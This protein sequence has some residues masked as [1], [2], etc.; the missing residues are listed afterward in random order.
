MFEPSDK[1][2]KAEVYTQMYTLHIYFNFFYRFWVICSLTE[3]KSKQNNNS[4]KTL[5]QPCTSSQKS[6]EASFGAVGVTV[7]THRGDRWWCHN[8]WLL[9]MKAA[10]SEHEKSTRANGSNGKQ[11]QCYYSGRRVDIFRPSF[12]SD[13]KT[14]LN[15]LLKDA[16]MILFQFT[17][18][19]R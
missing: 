7:T 5:H 4:T 2:T 8:S 13:L 1:G 16:R 14:S 3:K 18:L 9:C 17:V 12:L 10:G 6:Q 19:L 11:T 15:S